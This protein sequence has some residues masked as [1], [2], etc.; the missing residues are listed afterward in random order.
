MS[1]GAQHDAQVFA[2]IIP[3]AMVFVPSINGVSHHWTENTS[4]EDIVNGFEYFVEAMRRILQSRS[5]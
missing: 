2:S 4:D 3:T 5:K 1:S